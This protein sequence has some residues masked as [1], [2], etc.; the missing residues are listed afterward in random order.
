[1]FVVHYYEEKNQLLNQLCDNVPAVGDNLVIKGRKATVT[2]VT[3]LDEKHV[4]VHVT[5]EKVVK[6]QLALDLSK[7][8]K[9]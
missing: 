6:K 2:N 5:L 4:H 8:K 1:M 9:R 3:A 7:K